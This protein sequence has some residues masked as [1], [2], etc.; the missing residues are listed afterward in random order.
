MTNP[1]TKDAAPP[2]V[3]Y[4]EAAIKRKLGAAIGLLAIFCVTYFTAAVIATRDFRA[5]GQIDILGMP[6]AL[7]AGLLVFIVGLVVTRMCL[8]QDKGD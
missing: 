2:G 4:D 8:N 6:L 7:Y 5:I 1:S 3:V